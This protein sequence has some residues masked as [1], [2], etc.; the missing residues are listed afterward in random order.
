MCFGNEGSFCRGPLG[1]R[2]G[3]VI[4]HSSLFALLDVYHRNRW[5]FVCCLL[6]VVYI[7]LNSC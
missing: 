7:E 4:F 1:L 2:D 3:Y 5:F 6:A